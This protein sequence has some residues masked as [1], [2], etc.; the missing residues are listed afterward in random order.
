MIDSVSALEAV[1]EALSDA[2]R[3]EFAHWGAH[4]TTSH[5]MPGPPSE[6][7]VTETFRTALRVRQRFVRT[8]DG[9]ISEE[10]AAGLYRG[11]VMDAVWYEGAELVF[12]LAWALGAGDREVLAKLEPVRQY[13]AEL[14]ADIGT[15]A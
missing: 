1:V 15:D 7:P 14:V 10:D 2:D 11:P 12:G 9:T 5:G 4:F 6:R 8:G 3:V 13:L